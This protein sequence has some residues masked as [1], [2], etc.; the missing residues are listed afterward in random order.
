MKAYPSLTI[1]DAVRSETIEKGK[2]GGYSDALI[3]E[4]LETEGWLE[5]VTLSSVQSTRTARDL[6][7]EIGKGE[8]EAIALALEKKERLLMD[9][10]KGRQVADL[11]GIETT[12]TLGIMFELLMDGVLTKEDYRRNVKNYSSQGWITAEI[13]QEF[14]EQ[15]ER[16]N[17][18]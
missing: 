11:Y 16:V 7:K 17:Y 6:G 4:R 3:L 1:P 2:N 9:D 13:V 14:L 8:A 10:Q 18:E 15:G 5:T 12:T